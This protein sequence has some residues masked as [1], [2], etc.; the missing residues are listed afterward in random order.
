MNSIY[1]P[2]FNFM[3]SQDYY[4][5]NK[6]EHSIDIIANYTIM[7]KLALP[8]TQIWEVI[9]FKKDGKRLAEEITKLFPDLVAGAEFKRKG[10]SFPFY[11]IDVTCIPETLVP[12]LKRLTD[13]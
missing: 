13:D 6:I 12:I 4:N 11:H 1:N 5:K 3:R 7:F 2:I 9:K 8:S 10:T